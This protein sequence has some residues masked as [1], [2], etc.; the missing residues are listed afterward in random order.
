VIRLEQL[1][2]DAHLT[3]Q[4]LADAAGVSYQTVLN[5]EDGKGAQV[6]TLHKLA[7]ALGD[8]RPSELL[9][10]AVPPAEREV[11]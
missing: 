8:A 11:A 3:A 7:N 6:A 9:M 10:P 2:I 1:R 4:Q 5:I